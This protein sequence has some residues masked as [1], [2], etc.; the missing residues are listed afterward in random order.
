MPIAWKIMA[1]S[2]QIKVQSVRLIGLPRPDG[3][4]VVVEAG[5]PTDL[6]PRRGRARCTSAKCAAS[7][8]AV[9][10]HQDVGQRAEPVGDLASPRAGCSRPMI[11]SVARP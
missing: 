11:K 7:A 4:D 3:R 6:G 9:E 2:A 1:T 10:R 5:G 8:P